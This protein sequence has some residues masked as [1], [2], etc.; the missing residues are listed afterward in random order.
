M[1]SG[2]EFN[3]SWVASVP[4]LDH[5]EAN[6]VHTGGRR[7]A[8]RQCG[9]FAR[10]ACLAGRINQ[11]SNDSAYPWS[12]LNSPTEYWGSV[13]DHVCGSHRLDRPFCDLFTA[14]RPVSLPDEPRRS[15]AR[16]QSRRTHT[17]DLGSQT[18]RAPPP[19]GEFMVAQHLPPAVL[20]LSGSP[21]ACARS[22]RNVTGQ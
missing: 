16:T 7:L 2:A 13:H 5:L 14:N 18:R 8:E 4:R 10:N 12:S 6:D 19:V 20:G 11:K 1:K 21:T 15:P 22:T 9:F 3:G 17:S